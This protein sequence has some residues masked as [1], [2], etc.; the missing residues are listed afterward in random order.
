MNYSISSEKRIRNWLD[1]FNIWLGEIISIRN[2]SGQILKLVAVKKNNFQKVEE[3]GEYEALN[4]ANSVK[5][6]FKNCCDHTFHNFL[7]LIGVSCTSL[8]HKH[9]V[10][11]NLIIHCWLEL[12]FY[13]FDGLFNG[14]CT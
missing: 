3:V 4:Q 2:W 8:V 14:L 6:M 13:E 1:F 9:T 12:R 5:I 10:L 11:S 7:D